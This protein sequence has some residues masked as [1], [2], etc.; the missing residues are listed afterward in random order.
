M[1]WQGSCTFYNIPIEFTCT[2]C[3]WWG[4]C[5]TRGLF[6]LSLYFANADVG[7]GIQRHDGSDIVRSLGEIGLLTVA[8]LQIDGSG[9]SARRLKDVSFPAF[10]L[11]ECREDVIAERV[12][13]CCP[14]Y[15]QVNQKRSL[16]RPPIGRNI[17]CSV[18]RCE[19]QKDATIS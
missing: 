14:A 2:S 10:C 15:L 13:A 4:Y 8:T 5:F 3:H 12:R 16:V 11:M 1:M 18:R 6:D 7:N 9:R 19:R 17:R